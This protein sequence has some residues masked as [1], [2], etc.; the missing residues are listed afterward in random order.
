MQAGVAPKQGIGTQ[1][2]RPLIAKN[3]PTEEPLK[4]KKAPKKLDEFEKAEVRAQLKP[5]A[6]KATASTFD[7]W[8]KEQMID[9]KDY[10]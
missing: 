3:V 8:M 10:D 9:I 7:D 6:T 1:P 2:E 5:K 4:P